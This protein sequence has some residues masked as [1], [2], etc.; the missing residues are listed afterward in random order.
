MKK[1]NTLLTAILFIT[2]FCSTAQPTIEWQK[3]LGGTG[4]DGATTIQQTADGGYIV[5]GASISTD[6]DVTGNHGGND[7]WVVKLNS[8]GTITWQKCLGG[9]G[10]D[11]ASSIQQTIDGGYIVAGYS[12]STNGDV[13]GNHGG[14]DYWVIKL[15]STGSITWQKSL[16]GTSQD[17]AYAIQQ[18]ADGGYVVAGKS[19]SAN[20][21]V[22][23]N[24]GVMDYWVVKLTGTGAIDWQKSL[25]GTGDDWANSIQ[26]TADGG[27]II[28]GYS[29]SV[30][31]DVFGNHGS[32]D[33]WVV[34]LDSTG[35]I[36]WQ[37]SL[38]GNDWDYAWFI[39]Q[40]TDGGYIVAGYAYSNNGDVTSN[41]GFDDYWVVKLDSLG[42]IDWQECLGGTNS[43]RAISIQQTA[44]G[45]Y[46]VAGA[47]KSTNGDVTGN[48]GNYDY[49][50]VK[51]TNLGAIDWQKALGGTGGDYAYSIQQTADGGYI[52]AG[53]TTSTDGD[54]TGNHGDYDYWVVKLSPAVGVVEITELSEFSVFPNPTTNQITVKVNP[55]LVGAFYTVFDN[56]GKMVLSG[57]LN[58]ENTIIELGNLSGGIYLLNVGENSQ[59]TFK[60][61]KE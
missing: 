46:I 43:E 4:S 39:Q 48:H 7:Y 60:V 14:Q 15:D 5:A 6:G 47:S 45:G 31:G 38:G 1:I 57:Q 11:F 22:T 52:V 2:T 54:V 13:T 30:D 58:S 42:A 9:T 44:D 21:D 61:I 8:T 3:S 25:G 33:Y 19:S 20:G 53:Y 40:T 32:L 10:D 18:T 23:S 16:G 29:E 51:L 59:Q 34:K 28:V 17:Y 37:K 49:W 24:N 26:Q 12:E 35:A 41:H 55:K 27:Y 56:M 50:V 36:D